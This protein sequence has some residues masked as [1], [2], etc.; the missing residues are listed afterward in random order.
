MSVFKPGLATQGMD[1]SNRLKILQRHLFAFVRHMTVK[2]FFNFLRAEY[3]YARKLARLNS[4]PY[5][6]KIEST[7]ICNLRCKYCYDDRRAPREGERPYGRMSLAGFK[8]IVDQL[9]PYIFKINLYGYGEPLLYPETI[10][11]IEY[12]A[13]SNVGMAISSNL[14]FEDAD[15]PEKIVR[16]GLEVLI[17]SCHG[18]TNESYVN[19]TRKGNVDIPLGNI[20]RIIAE[21]RRL[22]SKT[23]FIDWQYCVTRF[24]E[25]EIELAKQKAA[26]LGVDQIRFIKP[27]VPPDA[28]EE[29]HSTLFPRFDDIPSEPNPAGCGWLYRAAYVN[30]DGGLMPCCSETRRV[31]RDFGNLFEKPFM[32]IWNNERY[33]SSRGLV[34]SGGASLSPE[35]TMCHGCPASGM[36]PTRR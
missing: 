11:M 2:K 7:N 30:Y 1:P 8:R 27:I 12:A 28:T 15:L 21:R 23:P 31:S 26:E 10:D 13:K 5:I 3:G 34:R 24:N 19:F 33:V 36:K 35:D 32:D 22:G 29:W 25:G 14:N 16:S 9:G 6:L 4:H 17:F 18:V 20:S